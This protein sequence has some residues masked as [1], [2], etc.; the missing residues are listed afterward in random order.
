MTGSQLIMDAVTKVK[1]HTDL[2]GNP[3][4]REDIFVNVFL[5]IF[6]GEESIY[7]ATIRD[8]TERFGALSR[9]DVVDK[10]NTVLFTV[11]P[12]M[13][14][15][16]IRPRKEGEERV[17]DIIEGARK[18]SMIHPVQ[19]ENFIRTKF[20][21][22]AN[23]LNVSIDNKHYLDVWNSIFKRYNKPVPFPDL[24]QSGSKNGS[25]DKADIVGYDPL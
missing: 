12:F 11:P 23:R 1:E 4:L 3:T 5:P 19:G 24:E 7:G 22:T 21:E 10:D 14:S 17:V 6:N 16:V 2:V 8:W 20:E 13:D 18:R 25:L 9:V 15:N